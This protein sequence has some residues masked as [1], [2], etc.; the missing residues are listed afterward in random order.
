MSLGPNKYLI[1]QPIDT[2]DFATPALLIDRDAL[3]ANIATMADLAGRR[4]MKL[5]PHVKAHKSGRIGRMQLDAGAAGVGC[6]TVREVEVMADAGLDGILLTT[7]VVTASLIARL[8]HARE[9][10]GGLALTV[11]SEAEVDLL[12]AHARAEKPIDILVDV[13]MGQGRTGVTNPDE[14]VRLARRISGVAAL[15]WRGVQAY[16]GHLQHVPALADRH[17]RIA[18]QWRYLAIVLDALKETGLPAGV[19]S[20]GG[21]GTHHLDLE[22]GPFTELQPGS[23]L[24]MDKQYG[25]VEIAPG[26]SPFRTALTVAARV[27]STAQPD[28][29]IV[30]A[31]SKALSID[32]G[33]ALIASGAAAGAAYQFMG[34]EHGA[35]LVAAG[36]MRPRLGD[37]ITFIAP[38]CDPT[39]NLYDQF[40]IVE[41]G[42]LVDIWPVEARG[43]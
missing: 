6:A 21:T 10:A 14:A 5:R 19:I 4:G 30:D 18:E 37:L 33:P 36:G 24:F 41:G 43:H 42:R 27:V 31:G 8:I 17:A 1:G 12:A 39:V 25:A 23:Y 32:A 2:G 34:D 15:R 28:R 35:V 13:D 26:G 20:G 29:V 40:H 22:H 11:D 38:H 7:P 3:K 9:K 16:Y